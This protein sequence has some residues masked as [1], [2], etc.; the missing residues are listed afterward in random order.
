MGMGHQRLQFRT[1]QQRATSATGKP[2]VKWLLTKA[3]PSQRQCLLLTIPQGNSEHAHGSLEGGLQPP[4]SYG[5]QQHLGIR[6]TSPAM[7]RPTAPLKLA[8]QR[9]VIIDLA[10]KHH[11]IA[12]ALGVHGL[13]ASRREIND[14]Q[15]SM[16]KCNADIGI[17]PN[18]VVIRSTMIQLLRHCP[19]KCLQVPGIQLRPG[20]QKAG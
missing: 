5:S 20:Q 16:A 12:P 13:M 11:H 10:V 4:C 14:C 6:V 18:T 15:A 3:V 8:S 2:V 9:L 1:E 17:H 7:P 19:G